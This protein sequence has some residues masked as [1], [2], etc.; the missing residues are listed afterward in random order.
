MPSKGFK[1]SEESKKKMS[2]TRKGQVPWCAGKK[3]SEEH[4]KKIGMAHKGLKMPPRTEEWRRKQRIAN[5]GRIVE[6]KGK[7]HWNWQ[8]G[9]PKC[10][11]CG[12]MLEDRRSKFCVKHCFLGARHPNWK[13]GIT[14]LRHLIRSNT[15]Y[16]NWRNRIL[17]RD[18]RRFIFCGSESQLEADHFP[19][20]FSFL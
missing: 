1:H 11:D 9:K 12:K 20:S 10:E 14:P 13:G 7:N 19:M 5:L 4:K 17:I 6:T 16:Y 18:K 15:K 2:I 3:L 8:G